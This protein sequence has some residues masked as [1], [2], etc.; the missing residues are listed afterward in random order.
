M[1]HWLTAEIFINMQTEIENLENISEDDFIKTKYNILLHSNI[2]F[3]TES[4]Q[5]LECNKSSK[6]MTSS[7]TKS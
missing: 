7:T 3:P 1:T 4:N 5:K 2:I 6:F